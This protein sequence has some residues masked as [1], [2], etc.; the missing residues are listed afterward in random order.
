MHVWGFSILSAIKMKCCLFCPCSLLMLRM[1]LLYTHGCLQSVNSLTAELLW[2][3][4]PFVHSIAAAYHENIFSFSSACPINILLLVYLKYEHW[5]LPAGTHSFR[6]AA[7]V[8]QH[9]LTLI[10]VLLPLFPTCRGPSLAVHT[11]AEEPPHHV[12][13]PPVA[14]PPSLTQHRLPS[15]GRSLAASEGNHRPRATLLFLHRV[16]QLSYHTNPTQPTCTTQHK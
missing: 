16:T 13:V 12:R 10:D 9:L 2:I 5:I 3:E 15:L 7:I 11:R 6:L 4:A 1:V 14:I 8:W